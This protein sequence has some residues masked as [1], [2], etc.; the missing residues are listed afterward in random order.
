MPAPVRSGE[1]GNEGNQKNAAT[2]KSL[3]APVR[4]AFDNAKPKAYILDIKDRDRKDPETMTEQRLQATTM[5]SADK[6]IQNFTSQWAGNGKTLHGRMV[7]RAQGDITPII[8]AIRK[9]QPWSNLRIDPVQALNPQK[10]AWIQGLATD[11]CNLE[12]LTRATNKKLK[13]TKYENLKWK[14]EK[15]ELGI[16]TCDIGVDRKK[17]NT[18]TMHAVHVIAAPVDKL[19]VQ[20]AFVECAFPHQENRNESMLFMGKRAVP[21]LN[22]DDSAPSLEELGIHTD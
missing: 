18:I 9:I 20:E 6:W 10:V 3:L 14:Y 21:S 12:S 19:K 13:G 8:E 4:K 17:D 11:S 16:K 2:I 7:V 5:W 1:Q 15:H 22:A